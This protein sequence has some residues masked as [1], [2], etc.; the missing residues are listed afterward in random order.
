LSQRLFSPQQRAIAIAGW[1]MADPKDASTTAEAIS[2]GTS[3]FGEVPTGAS[4]VRR[5]LRRV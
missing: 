5:T 4:L 1:S 2:T 3:G